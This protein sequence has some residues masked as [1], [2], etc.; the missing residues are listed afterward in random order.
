MWLQA[1]M[2]N[3]DGNHTLT[4]SVED[5]L[6]HTALHKKAV[7]FINDDSMY[8]GGSVRTAR[9][10]TA[11]VGTGWRWPQTNQVIVKDRIEIASDEPATLV[12]VAMDIRCNGTFVLVDDLFTGYQ[13]DVL[14]PLSRLSEQT[15]KVYWKQRSE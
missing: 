14:S 7:Q 4:V 5:L 8:I 9:V 11:I 2:M 13:T 6:L 1:R 12:K 10:V 3:D 15:E